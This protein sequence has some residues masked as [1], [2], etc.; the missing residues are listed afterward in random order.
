MAFGQSRGKGTDDQTDWCIACGLWQKEQSSG[1]FKDWGRNLLCPWITLMMI[2]VGTQR[3][4]RDSALTWSDH[5]DFGKHGGIW[6][7]YWGR[8]RVCLKPRGKGQEL[9]A[10]ETGPG[11]GES[12]E[13]GKGSGVSWDEENWEGI[14]FERLLRI[15]FWTYQFC[16][17]LLNISTIL[18]PFIF[19]TLFMYNSSLSEAINQE[20][21]VLY[22][23]YFIISVS[24]S[25]LVMIHMKM[26]SP[27]P[28]PIRRFKKK[29]TFLSH[30]DLVDNNYFI[31]CWT[32]KLPSC[33][34][35]LSLALMFRKL[36][37]IFISSY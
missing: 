7:G 31:P 32:S 33:F 29:T 19:H 26:M 3:W 9:K 36:C 20:Q 22:S 21:I 30:S 13:L 28:D 12:A 25:S 34:S 23:K 16:N 15:H 5:A 1:R 35:E 24:L 37:V 11:I 6:T 2:T 17:V 10:S 14:G 8:Y 18:G 27:I 4:K